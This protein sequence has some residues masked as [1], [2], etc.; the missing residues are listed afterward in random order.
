M[1]NPLVDNFNELT[2]SQ[3]DSKI[4]DLQ[5]KYFLTQNNNVKQQI[6]NILNMYKSERVSRLAKAREKDL[7]RGNPDLDGLINVN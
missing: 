4:S 2:D 1:F 7:A 5:R 6:V 3:L